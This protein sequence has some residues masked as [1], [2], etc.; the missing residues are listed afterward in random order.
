MT[1]E[2]LKDLGYAGAIDVTANT[3]VLLW[4]K[5]KVEDG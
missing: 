4:T 1:K 5:D 3:I 2:Y